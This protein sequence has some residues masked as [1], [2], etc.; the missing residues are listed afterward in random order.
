[1][2][3]RCTTRVRRPDR[4]PR[5]SAVDGSSRRN[6]RT[7]PM[8]EPIPLD[9]GSHSVVV[10][11][12]STVRRVRRPWSSSVIA[13]LQH[14]EREGFAGAPRALGFDEQGREVLTYIEGQV[15]YGDDFI[16]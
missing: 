8:S 9:G 15:G 10:R 1:M 7:G 14:V 13:L 4:R 2:V 5:R 16:P 3:S 12:G 6:D 11:V